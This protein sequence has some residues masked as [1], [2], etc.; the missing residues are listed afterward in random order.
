MLV[1]TVT[2]GPGALPY[3]RFYTLVGFTIN[4]NKTIINNT[5]RI[6][7]LDRGKDCA[8]VKIRESLHIRK[9]KPSLNTMQ[10]SWPL[11]H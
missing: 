1:E 2:D 7:I 6:D 3:V 11:T 4:N 9:L 5:F 8:E 10:S